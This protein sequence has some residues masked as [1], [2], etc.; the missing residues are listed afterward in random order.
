MNQNT[1]FPQN[2][3][4]GKCP[5]P[6]KPDFLLPFFFGERI[7]CRPDIGCD[8]TCGICDDM[9]ACDDRIGETW[10]DPMIGG[11]AN[12]GSGCVAGASDGSGTLAL[13][14]G[15]ESSIS[16]CVAAAAGCDEASCDLR[17]RRLDSMRS[18]RSLMASMCFVEE[19]RTEET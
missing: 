16:D 17:L 2:K 3:Y 9:T 4:R 11:A 5:Q 12:L 8:M 15:P 14:A 7:A 13:P 1:F 6:Q 18:L 10:L 19:A